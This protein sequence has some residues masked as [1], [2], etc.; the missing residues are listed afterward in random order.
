M[1]NISNAERADKLLAALGEQL[2]RAG[3]SFAVVVV[4][5]SGLLALG[6][7]DRPTRD[8]DVVAL[9]TSGGLV[10]ADPLPAPLAAARD[11]VGRDFGL[12]ADWLNA[13]PADLMDLG[14]PEGFLDRVLT[15][16]YGEGLTVHF[17]SR[18]D[19]IHL[20]LYAVVDQGPGRHEQDLR[21]LAPTPDELVRAGRWCRT[22]DPSEGFRGELERA[23]AHFSVSDA[24]LGA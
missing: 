11:R 16:R 12:P 9:H 4:G 6:L 13:G 23:L 2:G 8:V 20:K 21:A 3:E 14:L 24:D 22:H 19:Q 15:R 5:G 7:I 18:L 17:A 10:K 1:S